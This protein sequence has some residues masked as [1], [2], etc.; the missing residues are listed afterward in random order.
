MPQKLKVNKP[1]QGARLVGKEADIEGSGNGLGLGPSGM[2]LSTF[3]PG[4]EVKG[5]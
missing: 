1:S 2:G 4:R 5:H 3:P